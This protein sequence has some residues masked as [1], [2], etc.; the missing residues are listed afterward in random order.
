MKMSTEMMAQAA[1]VSEKAMSDWLDAVAKYATPHVK[2]GVP[3]AEAILLGH[4]D[5]QR[6]LEKLAS[7]LPNGSHSPEF[8]AAC[9]YVTTKAYKA[10]R[11]E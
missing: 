11:G 3:M 2:R 5:M 8:N 6:T 9:A 1:D 7:K 10:I 4:A